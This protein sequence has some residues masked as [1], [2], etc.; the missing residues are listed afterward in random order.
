MKA[1]SATP[2]VASSSRRVVHGDDLLYRFFLNAVER[3]PERF[4][5][6]PQRLISA[7]G[8]WMPLDVYEEWPILLPWVVRDPSSRGNRAKGVPD[9]WSSPNEA[10]YLR[11]DNSLVKALPR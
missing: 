10:G 7:V 1:P 8:V 2:A 3:E 6:L 9:S 5:Q 11:D 4:S